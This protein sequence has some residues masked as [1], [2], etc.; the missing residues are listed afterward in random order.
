MQRYNSQ[1]PGFAAETLYDLIAGRYLAMGMN[2]EERQ[3]YDYNFRASS[4]EFT[5]AALRQ[6]GVR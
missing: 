5:P 6:S 4:N 3:D 1:V 2:N